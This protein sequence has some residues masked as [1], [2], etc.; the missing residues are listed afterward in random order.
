MEMKRYQ[1]KVIQDL[2]RYMELLAKPTPPSGMK[3]A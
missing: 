1:K 3:K 2:S